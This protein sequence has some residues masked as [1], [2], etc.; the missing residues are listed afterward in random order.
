[1]KDILLTDDEV[2][3][4]NT[5]A[6]LLNR[7][8]IEAKNL[9]VEIAILSREMDNYNREIMERYKLDP[10][11]GYIFDSQR[12][13]LKPKEEEKKPEKKKSNK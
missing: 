4:L 1:M 2:I 6:K 13:V 3:N 11:K 5:R 12:G 9:E 10:G 7:K 8:K